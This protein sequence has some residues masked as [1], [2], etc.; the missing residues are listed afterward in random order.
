MSIFTD[1][2]RVSN[3]FSK[4][5]PDIFCKC[6]YTEAKRLRNKS[7]QV[8]NRPVKKRLFL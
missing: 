3:E 4:S 7:V 5:T 1:C 2:C 6:Q 8:R